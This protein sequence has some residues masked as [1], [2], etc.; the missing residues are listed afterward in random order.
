MEF[1]VIMEMILLLLLTEVP[2]HLFKKIFLLLL[3]ENIFDSFV[4]NLTMAK[5][6]CWLKM[7]IRV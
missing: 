2:I 5:Y 4:P 3:Y 6:C 1:F 7:H